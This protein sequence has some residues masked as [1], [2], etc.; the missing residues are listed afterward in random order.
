MD[1]LETTT[2][3]GWK[4]SGIR[5]CHQSV[6]TDIGQTFGM[7]CP[8]KKKNSASFFMSRCDWR[9]GMSGVEPSHE[10]GLFPLL[11]RQL[12]IALPLSP[13][14]NQVCA[15]SVAGTP[16][17]DPTVRLFLS[18]AWCIPPWSPCWS[19]PSHSRRA[20]ASSWPGRWE[21]VF[22]LLWQFGSMTFKVS[23]NDW[24]W[25]QT[26][27][28]S[29]DMSVAFVLLWGSSTWSC[30]FLHSKFYFKLEMIA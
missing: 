17:N 3:F 19:P 21:N 10:S 6:L 12:F 9:P 20:S 28:D 11:H 30:F 5:K 15:N 1:I 23:Q 18:G 26:K 29:V 8:F 24:L 16:I 14:R 22:A 25:F 13:L 7:N 4:L 2:T 27:A